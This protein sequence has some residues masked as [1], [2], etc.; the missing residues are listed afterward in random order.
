MRAILLA[1]GGVVLLALN[2]YA[3]VPA[4][5]S[6]QGMLYD[7][8]GDPVSGNHNLTFS[9][10]ND[11]VGGTAIWQETQSGMQIADG[12][13]ST[14]LGALTPLD[15]GLFADSLCWLGVSVNGAAELS[16]RA[17]LV[18]VPF[19]FK[20]ASVDGALAGS[21]KGDL[22]ISDKLTVGSSNYNPGK[23]AFC[24]GAG[25]STLGDNSA[26]IGGFDNYAY[27]DYSGVLAGTNNVAAGAY[28]SVPG[29]KGCQAAGLMS[30]AMGNNGNAAH[31]GCIVLAANDCVT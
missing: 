17:Q 16:P 24:A 31:D 10:Y 30:L 4:Q 25:N 19:A 11:P 29:G 3:G 6:Y 14:R 27:G 5:I 28:S 12:L 26:V 23:S 20:V 15:V 21:I 18:T 8:S 7:S 1:L 13:F 22:V 9:L 2:I